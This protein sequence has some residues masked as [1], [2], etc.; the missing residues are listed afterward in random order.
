MRTLRAQGS[1]AATGHAH[2][3]RVVEQPPPGAAPPGRP[4]SGRR[5]AQRLYLAGARRGAKKGGRAIRPTGTS[6]STG[7]SSWIASR[8]SARSEEHTS[9]LQSR[10]DLVCRLLLEKKKQ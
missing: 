5:D 1:P 7:R 6:I 2:A 3:S 8:T 4:A 10:V 9:Q